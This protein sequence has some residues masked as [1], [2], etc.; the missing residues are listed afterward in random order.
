MPTNLSTTEHLKQCGLCDTIMG[1]LV[2][3]STGKSS[4]FQLLSILQKKEND[5][6]KAF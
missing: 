2:E 6:C 1:L 5:V 3:M 4:F